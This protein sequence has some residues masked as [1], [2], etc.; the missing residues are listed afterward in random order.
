MAEAS[1]RPG[2][3]TPAP[4][5][6]TFTEVQEHPAPRGEATGSRRFFEFVADRWLLSLPVSAPQLTEGIVKSLSN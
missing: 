2:V 1:L 6:R 3:H 5:I 4:A